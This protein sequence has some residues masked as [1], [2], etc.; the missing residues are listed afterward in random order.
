MVLESFGSESWFF[1]FV[2]CV[3]MDKSLNLSALQFCSD[4][5]VLIPHVQNKNGDCTRPLKSV[6]CMCYNGV[7]IITNFY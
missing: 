6:L 5:K 7:I 3:T 4:I 2:H 1:L